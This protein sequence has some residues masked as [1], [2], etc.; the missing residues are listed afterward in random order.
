MAPESP[1]FR[2]LAAYHINFS[3]WM[4]HV[5]YNATVLEA[6]HVFSRYNSFVACKKQEKYYNSLMKLNY[7]T[8]RSMKLE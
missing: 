7:S 8:I 1:L 2:V 5:A 3:V 6:I 4:S